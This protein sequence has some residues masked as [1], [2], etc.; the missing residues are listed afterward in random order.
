MIS[1]SSESFS[2]RKCEIPPWCFMD[3]ERVLPFWSF[4]LMRKQWY[5][6]LLSLP[7][8]FSREIQPW[9]HACPCSSAGKPVSNVSAGWKAVAGEMSTWWPQ[10]T[11]QPNQLR[12][13]LHTGQRACFRRMW[14]L[15]INAECFS[16][17][18]QYQASLLPKPIQKMGL[19]T[20]LSIRLD[21]LLEVGGGALWGE[22]GLEK[23]E[24]L[25]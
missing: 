8:A 17:L 22:V 7:T 25:V 2:I 24:N 14:L 5:G 10:L 12:E 21:Q 15:I 20:R 1:Y 3:S 4:S 6:T 11:P 18:S 13:T 19:G 23:W 16:T 9:Y